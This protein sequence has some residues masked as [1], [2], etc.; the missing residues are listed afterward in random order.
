MHV[1]TAPSQ[2]WPSSKEAWIICPQLF[3]SSLLI[4]GFVMHPSRLV[5]LTELEQFYKY[6]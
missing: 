5:L 1:A 2:P 6:N 4:V 3:S